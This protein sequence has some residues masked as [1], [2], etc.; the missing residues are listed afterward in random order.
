METRNVSIGH[1][2]PPYT[3]LC[4]ELGLCNQWN[5]DNDEVCTSSLFCFAFFDSQKEILFIVYP[6]LL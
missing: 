2:C 6:R 5:V 1:V 4:Q 3:A